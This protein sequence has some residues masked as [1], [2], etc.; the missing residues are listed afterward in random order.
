MVKLSNDF[1]ANNERNHF[2]SIERNNST[3]NKHTYT[4][5]HTLLADTNQLKNSCQDQGEQK[6]TRWIFKYITIF[7]A[8]VIVVAVARKVCV[9]SCAC[10]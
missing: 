7:V 3:Q 8:I 10:V 9:C 6:Y 2:A 5:T 4:H 1:M